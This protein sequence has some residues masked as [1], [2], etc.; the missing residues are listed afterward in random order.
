MKLKEL[1]EELKISQKDFAKKLNVPPTNI[2]NYENGRTEPSI[3]L[4][5]QMANLLNVTVDYL[6]GRTDDFGVIKKQTPGLSLDEADLIENYRK[7]DN[8]GR[9]AISDVARS[10][11][12]TP[13]PQRVK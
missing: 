11:A 2:Y 8:V 13:A 10:L 4:L 6:I 5:I 12:N 7:C 3:A 9:V 1:R